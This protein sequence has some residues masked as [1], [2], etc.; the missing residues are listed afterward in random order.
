MKIREGSAVAFLVSTTCL[1][2]APEAAHLG[3]GLGGG[4]LLLLLLL[5]LL[6]QDVVQGEEA[7][8]AQL[9]GQAE[10]VQLGGE[11]VKAR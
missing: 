10:Q 9:V 5:L 8:R 6:L 7:E 1:P 2:A 3:R 4:D 11:W